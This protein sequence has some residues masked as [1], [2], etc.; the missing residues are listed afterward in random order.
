MKR[1]ILST[2][3][4]AMLAVAGASSWQPVTHAQSDDNG[5]SSIFTSQVTLAARNRGIVN[6]TA[7]INSDGTV[8]QCFECAPA[9]TTKLGTGIYQVDFLRD[10]RAT[11]GYFRFI[12]VDT[13]QTGTISGGVSCTTADRAGLSTAIYVK[14]TSA[15]SAGA[16]VDTSFMVIAFR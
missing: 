11:S 10:V 12:Q 1:F 8:A 6:F 9:T 3:L 5:G 4:A 7:A 14:C 13:L 15:A 16:E 2:G